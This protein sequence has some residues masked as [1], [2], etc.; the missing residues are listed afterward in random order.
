MSDRV[1][2]II[3]KLQDEAS[4]QLR[5]FGTN[6]ESLQPAFQKMTVAGTAGL[7]ALGGVIGKTTKD[8]VTLGES[9]NAV[10]VVFGDASERILQFGKSASTSVGLANAEFNQMATMTGA[11]LK[12]TGK[13]LDEVAQMTE[14]LAQ[15]GADLASVFNTDVN[16]AMSAINQ[17][18]R[19]ETEAIRRYTGDVTDATLQNYLMSKGLQDN[20][21]DMSESEKRLL[22][23][24]VLLEQTSFAQ[25]DFANTSDSLANQQRILNSQFKN[26]SAQIGTAF[27]PVITKLLAV[28]KP[29]IDK[30]ASWAQEN[31]NL[32]K[33]I[34]LVGLA[35][36]GLLA[37]IGVFGLVIPNIIAGFSAISSAIG[38]V[39][40]AFTILM[41]NPVILAFIAI[42]AVIAGLAYLIIKNWEAISTFFVNIWTAIVTAFQSAIDW[43]I[44]AITGFGTAIWE[45]LQM[46]FF[47]IVG[48]FATFLDAVFPGWEESLQKIW[49][50]ITNIWNRIK[51][52]AVIVWTA[53][54]EFFI[55]VIKTIIDPV[56]EAFQG[57]K[58]FFSTLWEFIKAGFT[59]AVNKIKAVLQPLI[60]FIDNILNKLSKIGN[61]IGGFG[62]RVGNAVSG[63][64]SNIV[65]RGQSVVGVNDAVISPGGQI[66][67]THPDDWLIAT[68]NPQSLG[69]GGG[70]VNVTITGNSFMGE[71]D[72][73]E[74]VGNQIL[75]IL[76]GNMQLSTV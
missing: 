34:L 75:N 8:A 59:E 13:P 68:K 38:L 56:V 60:D 20:V 23:M 26:I 11:L 32:A 14:T 63:F 62:G 19:G 50:T 17:A 67:T 30:F 39:G 41:A 73:A 54:K 28:V 12:T 10:Q 9:V 71:A 7:L 25:G 70:S 15:R 74:K 51:E 48:L 35:F 37:V 45:G 29:V 76:K 36:S 40:K 65:D 33:N 69:Q 16:D 58:D 43:I 24:Q 1:L 61:A 6:I 31:P 18:L 4:K 27:I 42:V 5:T 53:I 47:F 66:V 22:R 3:L 2:N 55:K 64:F 72:M 44:N 57:L 46:I 21:K 49:E 52:T